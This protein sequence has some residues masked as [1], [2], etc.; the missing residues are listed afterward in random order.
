MSTTFG[1][2]S[3]QL[4]CNQKNRKETPVVLCDRVS[5]PSS[6]SAMRLIP[7]TNEQGRYVR[8]AKITAKLNLEATFDRKHQ[9]THSLHK[10][11]QIPSS[12]KRGRKSHKTSKKKNGFSIT[13]R[14]N[15]SYRNCHSCPLSDLQSKRA[16][17][18]LQIPPAASNAC[19]SDLA[20]SPQAN[21]ALLCSDESK[22][23]ANSE[24]KSPPA[25][26]FSNSDIAL[27]HYKVMLSHGSSGTSSLGSTGIQVIDSD[28]NISCTTI[29]SP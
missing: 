18:G 4:P 2:V 27:P 1:V 5:V 21:P 9:R 24:D 29:V 15:S 17:F 10:Q 3:R 12:S 26:T 16:P 22:R 25:T 19:P 23:V 14:S 7:C 13:S 8:Q 6:V 11:Y 28:D 20:T